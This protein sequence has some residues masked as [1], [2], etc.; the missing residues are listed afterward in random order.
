MKEYKVCVKF[1]DKPDYFY[2][3]ISA[4]NNKNAIIKVKLDRQRR[5]D[6]MFIKSIKA[7]PT[8]KEK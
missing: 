7:Y 3:K 8:K 6:E 1:L 5:G 2:P 4:K